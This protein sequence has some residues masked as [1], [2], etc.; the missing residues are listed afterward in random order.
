MSVNT[1][2]NS[3]NVN[4]AY[5]EHGLKKT[6]TSTWFVS[7]VFSVCFFRCFFFCFL[8]SVLIVTSEFCSGAS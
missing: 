8:S 5:D 2:I 1:I 3:V 7:C 6:L 4:Q